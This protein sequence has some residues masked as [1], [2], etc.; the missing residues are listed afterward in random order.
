MMGEIFKI[1]DGKIR[2]IE[3]AHVSVPYKMKSGWVK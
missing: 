3:A 2:Q 1:E